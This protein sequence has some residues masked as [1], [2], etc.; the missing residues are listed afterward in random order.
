MSNIGVLD[1]NLYIDPNIDVSDL[2]FFDVREEPFKVYGL[3]NYKSEPEFK[4]MPDDVARSI[5]T[6]V[7]RL[8]RH[9]SGGRV[10]FATTSKSI[11]IKAYMPN[12]CLMAHMPFTGS[13]G[14]DMFTEEPNM[15]IYKH[16]KTFVPPVELENGYI[17]RYDFPDG[18]LRYITINFPL[19]NS[20]EKLEIGL[21]KD[22]VL[23]EGLGYKS[24]KPI[25]YYGSSITQG[26][27][28]SRPGNAYQNIITRRLE[29]DFINLGFS[30]NAKGEDAMTD[31]IRGLEMCAFVCDY[32]HNAPS[33]EHLRV[34]HRRMYERFREVQPKTPYIIVSKIDA[35]DTEDSIARREVIYETYKYARER[36]DRNVYFIDGAGVFRGYE[37]MTTVDTC[38]PNDLGFF[39][40]AKAF[41]DEIEKALTQSPIEVK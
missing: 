31:Y 12:T 16:V 27:C 28:A 6:G 24:D 26:G 10:R 1:K 33:P 20:L 7:T 14:F 17:S 21:A 11:A 34:T 15:R 19:Y 2:A 41:G 39:L 40:M 36:G 4:R 35:V 37:D 38:H 8:A 9:T 5:S 13:A 29:L 32:D 18:Q 3:Y 30:G 22:A 23:K 25:V